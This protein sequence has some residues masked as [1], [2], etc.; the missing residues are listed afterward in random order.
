MIEARVIEGGPSRVR[1]AARATTRW[2]EAA[3]VLLGSV[4]FGCNGVTPGTASTHARASSAPAPAGDRFAFFSNFAPEANSA[5]T[6]SG[7]GTSGLSASILGE[8]A[9]DATTGEPREIGSVGSANVLAAAATSPN[10]LAVSPD[11]TELAIVQGNG[12][13]TAQLLTFSIDATNG[14]LAA[15]GPALPISSGVLPQTVAF[16]NGGSIVV[17]DAGGSIACCGASVSTLPAPPTTGDCYPIS[18]A[19]VGSFVYQSYWDS[20]AATQVGNGVSVLGSMSPCNISIASL[21]AGGTIGVSAPIEAEAITTVVFGAPSGKF[22]FLTDANGIT[23]ATPDPVTG[24]L[25][26]GA[27][28]PF[29][30]DARLALD[31]TGTLAFAWAA[32]PSSGSPATIASFAID[33]ATGALTRGP[34]LGTPVSVLG[35][36]FD[37]QGRFAYVTSDTTNYAAAPGG[38]PTSFE[39]TIQAYAIG[40]QGALTPSGAPLTLAEATSVALAATAP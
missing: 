4:A 23:V 17:G 31:P 25:T 33:A 10:A 7:P 13:G 26:R 9:L 6:L 30:A 39:S 32:A 21:G 24:S 36:A 5:F 28:V 8:L 18:V 29:A 2:L 37:R 40:A 12:P 35:F 15:K 11:G 19:V 27:L 3:A 20:A 14:S 22:V 16:A 1:G 38:Q 34:G